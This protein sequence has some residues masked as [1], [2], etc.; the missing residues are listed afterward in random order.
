MYRTGTFNSANAARG[1]GSVNRAR[2]QPQMLIIDAE[3]GSLRESGIRA[4]LPLPIQ[5][6]IK[7]SAAP[8]KSAA[9]RAAAAWVT[10]PRMPSA[11]F[12][13]ADSASTNEKSTGSNNAR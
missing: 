6:S 10:A 3:I 8:N 2:A 9:S 1:V 7:H 5:K 4:Q 11:S 13:G 12:G